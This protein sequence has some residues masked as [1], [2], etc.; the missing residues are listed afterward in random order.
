MVKLVRTR[1]E[2]NIL[3]A[4]TP[5]CEIGFVPTMGNLHKGHLSLIKKAAQ[6]SKLIVVSIFVNPTQFGPNEDFDNYPRT[7]EQDIRL[8]N[9]L[10]IKNNIIIFAPE[11]MSEIYPPN[12]STTFNIPML[13]NCLCGSS[14][15]GHFSG[16]LSVVYHLFNLIKPR[17]AVFGQKD[18][19]QF[20]II[21]KFASDF[22]PSINIIMSEIIREESG[23]A[24]SSRNGYLT[25]EEKVTALE[26][27]KTLKN[28]KADIL[29]KKYTST[30]EYKNDSDSISWDYLDVLDSNTLQDINDSTRHII[31]SGA[32]FINRKVRLIDNILME[33]QA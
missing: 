26:L 20:L 1:D 10:S 9:D 4:D 2:F 15:P 23:L 22:F 11:S 13:E 16:V 14:R 12:F 5:D 28:V 31:I 19:Q 7:L 18:Y 33:I 17:F 6:L 21:K 32:M 27:N 8:I 3:R 25:E 30:K 24:M 29:S